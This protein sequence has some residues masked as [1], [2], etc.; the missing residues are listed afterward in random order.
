MQTAFSLPR[1]RHRSIRIVR[2]QLQVIERKIRSAEQGQ[3]AR[4]A[5]HSNPIEEIHRPFH[6]RKSVKSTPHGSSV[7]RPHASCKFFICITRTNRHRRRRLVFFGG[8]RLTLA[9]FPKG[10]RG[11]LRTRVFVIQGARCFDLGLRTPIKSRKVAQKAC[12][13][14]QHAELG[15]SQSTPAF[16]GA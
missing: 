13:A 15:R 9:A 12:R 8:G 1:T 3:G 5:V 14:C 7:T 4:A 11:R 10:A 6:M 16:N 2:V